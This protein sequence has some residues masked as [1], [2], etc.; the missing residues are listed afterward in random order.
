MSKVT[1]IQMSCWCTSSSVYCVFG[2]WVSWYLSWTASRRGA[3]GV[4]HVVLTCM[5]ACGCGYT[6]NYTDTRNKQGTFSCIYFVRLTFNT[7]FISWQKK[8]TPFISFSLVLSSL[9]QTKRNSVFSIYF[10]T[11]LFLGLYLANKKN[12][13]K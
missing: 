5:Y 9:Q 12:K 1:A 4:V 10:L 6:Y 7:P 3:C 13:I 11:F 2:S 8:N